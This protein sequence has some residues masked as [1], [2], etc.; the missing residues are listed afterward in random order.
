MDT[1]NK[2][3]TF[4][5]GKSV[6]M[7]PASSGYVYHCRQCDRPVFVTSQKYNSACEWEVCVGC[8]VYYHT[9]CQKGMNACFCGSLFEH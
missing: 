2:K 9:D 8:G 1:N 5:R 4:K 7:R 6:Q 3:V